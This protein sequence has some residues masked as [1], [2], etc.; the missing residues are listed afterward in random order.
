MS[1]FKETR[2][3][4]Q[5][6]VG[7]YLE[8]AD[9]TILE[10]QR[11]LRI[12]ISFYDFFGCGRKGLNVLD[13]G[14][15]DGALV[16]TLLRHD[17]TLSATMVDGSE[18]MLASARKRFKGNDRLNYI[19]ASFQE[20]IESDTELPKFDLVVS[21][22]AIHHLLIDEKKALFRYIHDHLKDGGGFINVDVVTSPA[23]KIEEWYLRLWKEWVLERPNG[24]GNRERIEGMITK[25]KAEEHHHTL[26]PLLPQLEALKEIGFK[27]VDCFY[28]YGIFAVFGGEK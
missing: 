3:A 11:L 10:R 8:D 28:K 24:E 12:I 25:H 26:D 18:D 16:D 2:W 13:L 17:P 23:D 27:G 15:G 6:Y 21:S 19:G 9:N 14:C 5:E 7:K 20:L 4:E 22:L 1:E